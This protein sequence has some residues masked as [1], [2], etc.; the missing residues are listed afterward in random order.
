MNLAA[1]GLAGLQAGGNYLLD[2]AAENRAFKRQK[3]WW[4][5]QF[6][7]VNEY[8]HPVSQMKRLKAAGLNPAMMYGGQGGQAAG[9]A[10]SPNSSTENINT[11]I[12]GLE[13]LAAISAQT[14]S[15]KA[16]KAVKMQQVLLD[17][18]RA[19]TERWKGKLTQYQAEV[20]KD[21]QN[22]T[23]DL[24]KFQLET[25]K[26]E[27]IQARLDTVFKA[28]EKKLAIYNAIADYEQKMKQIQHLDADIK[29][30][31]ANTAY[32]KIINDLADK[33]IFINANQGYYIAAILEE[34]FGTRPEG[35]A[36]DRHL[37]RSIKQKSSKPYIHMGKR[38]TE[39]YFSPTGKF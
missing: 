27:M 12:R 26:Q 29:Q 5:T 3:E 16:D 15:L 11:P 19:I 28:P 34:L 8:N 14:E 24:Y 31:E 36:L 2:R 23:G 22:T 33:K 13:N 21:L 25:A 35:S 39:N 6:T 7:K 10:Q 1:F 18:Q 37:K 4:N 32:Q 30:K 9:T 20:Q 17:S 38:H